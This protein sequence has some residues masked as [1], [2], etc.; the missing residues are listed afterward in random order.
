MQGVNTGNLGVQNTPPQYGPVWE[1][2]WLYF[3]LQITKA[4]ETQEKISNSP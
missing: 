2:L 3:E 4:Q 1:V